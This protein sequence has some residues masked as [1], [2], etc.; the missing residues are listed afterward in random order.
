MPLGRQVRPQLPLV[1]SITLCVLCCP[2]T[3]FVPVFVLD[4]SK[5]FDSIRHNQLFANSLLYV[6]L[7]RFITGLLTFSLSG[8]TAPNLEMTCHLLLKSLPVLFRGL[9][10]ARPH[11]LSPQVTCNQ[12]TTVMKSSNML[13]THIWLCLL[14]TAILA[15]KSCGESETGQ[16]KIIFNSMLLSLGRLYSSPRAWCSYHRRASSK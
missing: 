16:T 9:D 7:M 6:Y 13:T 11:M 8:G 2:V 14:L 4:F 10:L 3:K 15:L 12:V 1:P 5:A